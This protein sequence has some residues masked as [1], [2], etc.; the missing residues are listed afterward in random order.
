MR[1]IY[2]I[3]AAFIVSAGSAAQTAEPITVIGAF[4]LTG[5]ASGL[6]VAAHNGA[7]LAV[8][9]INQAG[10]IDGRPIAFV[11][12][13][14]ESDFSVV[15]SKVSATLAAHPEAVAG[16]GYTYSEEALLAGRVFQA[17]GLPFISPGATDPA[18]P[19]EVGDDMF[20]VAYGDDAQAEAMARFAR[21]QLGASRAA[22]LINQKRDY[23]KTVGR[24]FTQSFQQLGGNIAYSQNVT[25][26]DDYASFFAAV[27][28]TQ[29]DVIYAATLPVLGPTFIEAA[30]D[31]GITLPLLSADGWDED[32]IPAASKAKAL[33]GIYFTTHRFIGVDTPAMKAF[34][35]AYT[36]KFGAAPPNAFAPLGFDA[37]NLLDNAIDR[38][39]S[40]DPTAIRNAL[41]TTTD[42]QGVVG[43]V[44]YTDDSRVPK[45]AVAVIAVDDGVESLRWV[46]PAD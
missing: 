13:N 38:A 11:T 6:D 27:K 10:G 30:R 41:A 9:L 26:S 46:A 37:V 18:V 39:G 2:P 12:V 19:G 15:A 44:A 14:T 5:P 36:A 28:E 29:A 24:F 32:T 34:V 20:Y 31:A 1:L 43:K 42:F 4:D 7:A 23:T 40:T 35:D 17:A 22:V 3:A 16:I 21:D 45:K 8:D 33:T 25:G